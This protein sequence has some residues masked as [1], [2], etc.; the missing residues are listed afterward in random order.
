[1]T[2]FANKCDL[3]KQEAEQKIKEKY[4][5]LRNRL[6]AVEHETLGELHNMGHNF[7]TALQS[8]L[9]VEQKSKSMRKEILEKQSQP[10]NSVIN[11][12]LRQNAEL[13]CKETELLV[14]CA[15]EDP[16]LVLKNEE[17]RMQYFSDAVKNS[18]YRVFAPNV[19][20]EFSLDVELL[21]EDKPTTEPLPNQVAQTEHF[22]N[23]NAAW[24]TV[25]DLAYDNENQRIFIVFKNNRSIIQYSLHGE[26]QATIKL[27][28][29]PWRLQ[30]HEN[31]LYFSV[32]SLEGIFAVDLVGETPSVS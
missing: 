24:T 4:N 2:A 30:I 19:K 29:A 23:R 3:F 9:H 28:S 8:L 6:N 17:A 12:F 31:V 14:A 20:L 21:A 1:M 32:Q 16:Q 25:R 15:F 5:E 26:L 18:S 27:H 11:S 10:S 7:E 22:Q 13:V